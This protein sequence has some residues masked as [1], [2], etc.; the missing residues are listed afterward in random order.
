MGYLFENLM[1]RSFSKNGQVAGEFYTPRDAIRMMIDV[2]LNSD[3]DGL[4]S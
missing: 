2:L 4:H 1:Y 3:D